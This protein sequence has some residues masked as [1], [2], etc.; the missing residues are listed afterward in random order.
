MSNVYLVRSATMEPIEQFKAVSPSQAA[1]KAFNSLRRK[2][3]LEKNTYYIVESV[4]TKT[5]KYYKVELQKIEKQSAH[6]LKY[7]IG[8]KT[9]ATKTDPFIS[10]E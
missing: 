7:N 2:N 3:P 6:E 4:F 10:I 8:Y 1:C 5:L 9:V